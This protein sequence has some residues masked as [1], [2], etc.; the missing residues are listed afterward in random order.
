MSAGCTDERPLDVPRVELEQLEGG[1]FEIAKLPRP[2]QADCSG[3]TSFYHR[4]ASDEIAVVHECH[5]GS[6]QGPIRRVAA[7]AVVTDPEEPAKWSL[8][9]GGFYGDYWIVEVAPDYRYVVVGHPSRDYLWILS[10]TAGMDPADYEGVVGRMKTTGFDVRRLE[11]TEQ[12][13]DRNAVAPLAPSSD[14]PE[15]SRHGCALAPRAPGRT[16]ESLGLILVVGLG[17]LCARRGSKR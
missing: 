2:T 9:F 7:R 6:L 13:P 11:L 12:D 17:A 10:R 5:E 14:V 4:V 1:Y 8:D 16:S 3:T 15:L